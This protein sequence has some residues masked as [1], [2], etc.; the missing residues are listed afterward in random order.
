[1]HCL[2]EPELFRC[3]LYCIGVWCN[4]VGA[5]PGACGAEVVRV[6]VQHCICACGAEVVRV[7]VQHSIGACGAEVVRVQVMCFRH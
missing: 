7:L 3:A 2:Q 5:A 6:L 1:M 4:S